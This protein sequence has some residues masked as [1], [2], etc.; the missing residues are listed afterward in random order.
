MIENDQ[1]DYQSSHSSAVKIQFVLHYFKIWLIYVYKLK[2]Y[3][4][5]ILNQWKINE[6]S[7]I[8]PWEINGKS[9][10]DRWKI[11]EKWI[12]EERCKIYKDKISAI[13]NC[14]L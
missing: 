7:M 9:M 14:Y 3:E 2:I 4:K 11:N 10:Q 12:L 1:K 8:N 6:K 5:S 13:K